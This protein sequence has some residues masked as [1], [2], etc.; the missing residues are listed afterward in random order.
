M[1]REWFMVLVLWGREEKMQPQVVTL[2]D[3]IADSI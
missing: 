1:C 2:T 3:Y